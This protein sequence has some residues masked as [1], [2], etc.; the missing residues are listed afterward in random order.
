MSNFILEEQFEFLEAR[1]IHE[2]IGTVQEGLHNIKISHSLA[3]VVKL[4]L[5]KAR[6]KDSWLYL[7][8]LLI[9]ICS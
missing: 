8:L 7:C 1:Q 5:S 2:A 3:I 9:H 4:D 6:D